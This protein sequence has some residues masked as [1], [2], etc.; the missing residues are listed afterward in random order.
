MSLGSGV[1]SINTNFN[2]NSRFPTKLYPFDSFYGNPK[3]V[4]FPDMSN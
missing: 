1:S 2:I 3:K 4:S